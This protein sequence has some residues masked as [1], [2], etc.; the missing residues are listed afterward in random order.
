LV[1][2]RGDDGVAG[3]VRREAGSGLSGRTM[4]TGRKGRW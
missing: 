2:D 4:N 1:N 3:A